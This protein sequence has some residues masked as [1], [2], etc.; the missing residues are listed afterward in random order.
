MCF[1]LLESSVSVWWGSLQVW[2]IFTENKKINIYN[3][4]TLCECIIISTAVS[5]TK[6]KRLWLIM[7]WSYSTSLDGNDAREDNSQV[8]SYYYS[9]LYYL[10]YHSAMRHHISLTGVYSSLH[11]HL[12]DL[13][14]VSTTRLWIQYC[15]LQEWR[16]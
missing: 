12:W 11:V 4:R 5:R 8:V 15:Y 2:I 9:S 3:Y 14:V 7:L 13:N 6:M 16:W 10:R 1:G